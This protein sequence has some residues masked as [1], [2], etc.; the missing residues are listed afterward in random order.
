MCQIAFDGDYRG[1]NPIRTI[2]LHGAPAKPILVA[3]HNWAPG[4]SRLS[5]EWSQA[6]MPGGASWAA[7]A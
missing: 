5:E 7:R 3:Y 2:C 4:S 1:N 6:S